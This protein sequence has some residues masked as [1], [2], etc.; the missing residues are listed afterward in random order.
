MGDLLKLYQ[1]QLSL[2]VGAEAQSEL[3]VESAPLLLL[4]YS[5]TDLMTMKAIFITKVGATIRSVLN[6][7]QRAN[8]D[9]AT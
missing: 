2:L 6:E 8:K 5:M 9:K 3:E 7:E 1:M 4:R